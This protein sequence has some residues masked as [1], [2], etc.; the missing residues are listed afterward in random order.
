[1]RVPQF[2]FVFCIVMHCLKPIFT[3]MYSATLFSQETLQY[4]KYP[5]WTMLKKDCKICELWYPLHNSGMQISLVDQGMQKSVAHAQYV[6]ESRLALIDNSFC[7]F[8]FFLLTFIVEIK[9]SI[10]RWGNWATGPRCVIH[11]LRWPG[12]RATGPRFLWLLAN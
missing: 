4:A 1:M 8:L 3:W 11:T 10:L 5:V 6:P 7:E 12:N 2:E 9:V